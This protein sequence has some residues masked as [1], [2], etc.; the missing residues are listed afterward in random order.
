M[1]EPIKAIEA[2]KRNQLWAVVQRLPD[3][4]G[5]WMNVYPEVAV[6]VLSAPSNHIEIGH[7]RVYA[8]PTTDK[9][10]DLL[11]LKAGSALGLYFVCP[12]CGYQER[13]TP[14]PLRERIGRRAPKG[15]RTSCVVCSSLAMAFPELA[16][17]LAKD[18]ASGEKPSPFDVPTGNARATA[19]FRCSKPKCKEIVK[20]QVKRLCRDRHLPVCADC[21]KEISKANLPS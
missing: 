9:K 2:K 8:S 6:L 21:R 19:Y 18:P 3:F 15:G 5:S 17:L 12:A 11:G 14:V 13:S 1:A 20:R 16:K 4:P 10:I 7:D